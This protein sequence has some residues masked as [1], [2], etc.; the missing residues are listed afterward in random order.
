[1]ANFTELDSNNIVIQTLTVNDKHCGGPD[2]TGDDIGQNFLRKIH[3]DSTA[4]WKRTS[5]DFSF[6][7]GLASKGHTYDSVKDKF[8]PSQPFPSWI[9]NEATL[10]WDP[11]SPRPTDKPAN[12]DEDS[13]S[14]HT[15]FD[16]DTGVWS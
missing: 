15:E 8:I 1:M 6:R 16:A 5:E 12:W 13:K 11:P 10:T 2:D 14:W 4:I 3:L 9:L 7:G